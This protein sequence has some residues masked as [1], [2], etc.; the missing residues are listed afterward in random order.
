MSGHRRF[1]IG[2]AAL[3]GIMAILQATAALRE[4][5]TWD[6]AIHLA[7]GYSY[8]KTGDVK[9][10]FEHPPLFKLLGS[11]P[12]LLLNPRLPTDSP[13]WKA[14]NQVGFGRVFLYENRV[15]PDTMLF[16]GRSMFIGLT[17]AL[18]LAIALWTRRRFGPA[19]ALFALLLFAFD[20]NILAHGH[21]VTNDLTVTLFI[22][23]AVI[24]WVKFLETKRYRDLAVASAMAGLAVASKFS[25][26][27][28]AP[29]LAA[30]YAFEWWREGRAIGGLRRL[31]LAHFAVSGLAAGLIALLVI[32]AAY[33]PA[34]VRCFSGPPITEYVNGWTVVGQTLEWMGQNWRLP[35]HPFLIGI[36]QVANFSKDGH[37]QYLLG[38][39]SRYGWWYYFP[40]T[41]VVKTPSAVLLLLAACA[42]LGAWWLARRGKTDPKVSPAAWAT[43][44]L[45][46]VVYFGLSML[47]TIDLGVR[48]LLPIYPF[49][50]ILIAA[51]LFHPRLDAH[52]KARRV[53]VVVAI[54]LQLFESVP[55]YPHYLA[56]FNTFAGGPDNGPR[57]LLDSN[58]DW[59][60]DLKELKRYLEARG[61]KRPVCFS[62]FGTAD[63]V[64]YGLRIAY[65]P[66]TKDLARR[67]AV[68]CI[69]AISVTQLYEVYT[70]R[71]V[72]AWLRELK[73]VAKVG[74]SIYL[75]DLRKQRSG[76]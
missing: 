34:T 17:V 54:A 56:F 27:A 46:V 18:G 15:P 41:F 16:W 1:W 66:E 44:I 64:Y 48:Y 7:A 25:G 43:L 67:Q 26:V 29:M 39:Y 6:E 19:A 40:V 35:A 49:L 52:G 59:G 70:P 24:A 38:Q 10:N 42:G 69:A 58:I 11:F 72:Y 23:L 36:N 75:Y 31:S 5:Q 73:P 47:S 65:L 37:A 13:T 9:L 30:L 33:G 53:I 45:P 71:G 50:F 2:A 32:G 20:P 14:R 22:F 12:L 28:L 62:Y 3:L 61:W 60:Q 4:N 8:W 21:Y 68:D 57:Y 51:V 63:F 76:L 55:I 74:Y